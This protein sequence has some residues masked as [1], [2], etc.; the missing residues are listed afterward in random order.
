MTGLVAAADMP[1]TQFPAQYMRATL[2]WHDTPCRQGH[3]RVH[4][5]AVYAMAAHAYAMATIIAYTLLR[6]NM[7]G[8]FFH[9]A[10][11]LAVK[12]GSRLL[13]GIRYHAEMHATMESHYDGFLS[14]QEADGAIRSRWLRRKVTASR[15]RCITRRTA[16]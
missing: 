5:R 4:G 14:C 10:P 3:R 13:T 2:R 7:G 6:R 9:V 16:G 8:I 12:S 15:A 11:P 1:S